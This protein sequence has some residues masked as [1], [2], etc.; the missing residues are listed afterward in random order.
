M[1]AGAAAVR[2]PGGVPHGGDHRADA[3]KPGKGWRVARR[4]LLLLL[5][6]G[7][8]VYL[9]LPRVGEVRSALRA[10]WHANPFAVLGSLLAAA[11]TFL[12]GALA[13][14]SA[15]A[16]RLPLRRTI[17]VQLATAFA[18]LAPSSVGALAVTVRYLQRQGIPL[19]RAAT[20]TA[21][22]RVAGA[23]SVLLLLPVLL[24]FARRTRPVPPVPKGFTVLLVV[25]AGSLL[26]A[27]VLALPKL[28][29]RIP[30]VAHQVAESLRSLTRHRRGLRLLWV[31]L[32]LTLAYGTCLYLALLAVGLPADLSLVPPVL[33]LGILSEGVA[34][35]AP[36][37]G[38]LGAAEA[39]LVSGLLIYGVAAGPAV[40]G[41][42]IYRFATFWL[43]LAPGFVA[44][45]IL[46]R[47]RHI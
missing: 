16:C 4:D 35:V 2:Q 45:R 31:S 41:A 40:A 23:L 46:S 17:A 8:L 6:L 12:F 34:S 18:N 15:A 20:V 33:L 29:S 21:T 38:G 14:R 3:G 30:M 26:V 22:V 39:A 28:R 37:P 7:L 47:R 10:L 36:T 32:A 24:P 11:A 1:P 13:L 9:L 27:V 5:V 25:L 19:A 42:L 44:L 43:P